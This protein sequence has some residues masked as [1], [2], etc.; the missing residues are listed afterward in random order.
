MSYNLNFH[1][2]FPPERD[3]IAQLLQLSIQNNEFLTKEEISQITTI[4]TG[5]SSGKVVPNIIYGEQMGLFNV[6]NKGGKFRISPTLIGEVI[7]SEDPYFLEPITLWG[8]HFNLA[9]NDSKSLLWSYVFNVIVQ[10]GESIEKEAFSNIVNKRFNAKVNLTPLRSCYLNN[11][12]FATLGIIIDEGSNYL[13]VKH[14]IEPSFKF[15][16]AFQFLNSWEKHFKDRTEI[17]FDEITEKLYFGN[18]Y[19]WGDQD[20]LNLLELLQDERIVVL[21]RQLSPLTVVRQEYS[22]NLLKQ[23]YSLLI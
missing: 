17:T 11:R 8:C 19:L 15:L 16:Y 7:N 9:D 10:L 3:A 20:V 6:E 22:N 18:P 2:S 23:V 14:K 1:Q 13:F 4:P 12:S 21:N 5:E